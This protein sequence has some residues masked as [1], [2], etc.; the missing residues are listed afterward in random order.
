MQ[1]RRRHEG[2]SPKHLKGYLRYLPGCLASD[3]GKWKHSRA[4][5]RSLRPLHAPLGVFLQST[6]F[7]Q[8]IS[9]HK[10]QNREVFLDDVNLILGNSIKYNGELSLARV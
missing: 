10:Y 9:K 7:F 8:N 6:D 1:I 5:K 3:G 4:L 2:G